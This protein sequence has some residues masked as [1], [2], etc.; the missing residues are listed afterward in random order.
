MIRKNIIYLWLSA[1][2][3][4]SAFLLYGFPNVANAVLVN[5]IIAFV[6]SSPVTLYDF[7][8]FNPGAFENYEQAQNDASQGIFTEDDAQFLS[9]TKTAL[10]LLVDKILIRQEE[11]KAAIYIPPKYIKLY[12][13]DVAGANNFTEKQFFA[14]LKSKGISKNDYIKHIRRHFMEIDLLRKIYGKKMA[15]TDGEMRNYYNNNIEEFRG[16]PMVDLKMI[17]LSVPQGATQKQKEKIFK[18][19]QNIRNKA[20]SGDESFSSLARKFSEDSS[21]KNGGRIGYVYKDKLSPEFSKYAFSLRVGEISKI[22]K[23]PFGFTILKPVGKKMGSYKTFSQ[24]KGQIFSVIE[25]N[26][27]ENYLGKLL[28]K[29]K[30]KAYIK[31]L[32]TV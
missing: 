30:K 10:N 27:T 20:I 7:E 25:K 15:V 24:V 1:F 12:I 13:K 32:I 31:I 9:Q 14:F 19:M 5:R 6:N 29:A 23:S 28:K 2:V 22:I 8:K 17:F 3:F 26:K 21:E 16:S 4:T 18:L 11:E